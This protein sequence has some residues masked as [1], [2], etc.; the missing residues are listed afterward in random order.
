MSMRKEIKHNSE[1][2]EIL[3]WFNVLQWKQLIFFNF[4]TN[5]RAYIC[6]TIDHAND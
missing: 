3:D 2:L 5:N 6:I 1:I 4:Q